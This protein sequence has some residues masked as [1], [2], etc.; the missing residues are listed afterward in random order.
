MGNTADEKAIVYKKFLSRKHTSDFA[1][2]D[3]KNQIEERKRKNINTL[4]NC[5]A[6]EDINEDDDS[7]EFD[8]ISNINPS[9]MSKC[10][11]I[12]NISSNNTSNDYKA[13]DEREFRNP[14]IKQETATNLTKKKKIFEIYKMN[15]RI[16]RIKK[17]SGYIGK[18]NKLSEDNV[19][20]KIKRRFLENVRIYINKEY[21]KYYHKK[22]INVDNN[23]WIKKISPKFYGQ[24]KKID[25][26]KWFNSKIFEVFS[27]NLSLRYSSHSLD[28]NKQNILKFLS[29]NESSTL[30]DI[31]NTKVEI[32][33]SRYI[34]NVKIEGF[35]TLNDD[36][37]EL[38]KQ[39]KDS[40]Q[41]NIVKYLKKYEDTAKN[42]KYIF[43]KKIE[44]KLKTK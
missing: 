36:I 33:F 11:D 34:E 23:N 2:D 13:I 7:Y 42:L 17:N 39:M 32:L 29:S 20:R 6:I 3:N 15:K 5:F 43:N 24:I 35:K 16:G 25:N 12:I 21:K 40:G 28:S 19:I 31:L 4:G 18:H 8:T 27:E 10:F 41:D 22:K 44:R 30:K 9:Y 1:D 14:F 37:K 26:I 38:E